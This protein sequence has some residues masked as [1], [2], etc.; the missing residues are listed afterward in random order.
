LRNEGDA[1]QL[2]REQE[3]PRQPPVLEPAKVMWCSCFDE[4]PCDPVEMART[5]ESG[6]SDSDPDSLP[7]LEIDSDSDPDN[8][9]DLENSISSTPRERYMEHHAADMEHCAEIARRG[10]QCYERALEKTTEPAA[11]SGAGAKGS[12]TDRAGSS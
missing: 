9:S 12:P 8:L 4:Q 2:L 7:D 6:D 11:G 1:V 5:S 10:R 3:I